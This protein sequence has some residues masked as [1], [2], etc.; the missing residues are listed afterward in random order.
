MPQVTPYNPVSL[1]DIATQNRAQASTDRQLDQRA[2][3]FQQNQQ[4]ASLQDRTRVQELIPGAIVEAAEEARKAPEGSR[5]NKFRTVLSPILDAAQQNGVDVREVANGLSQVAEGDFTPEGIAELSA[6]MQEFNQIT[7]GFTPE[8]RRKAQLIKA[9]IQPR[10]VSDQVVQFGDV[11]TVVNRNDGTSTPLATPEQIGDNKGIV[12]ASVDASKQGVKQSGEAIT[13]L[14]SVRKNVKNIDDAIAAIDEGANT[15]AIMS[16][17]PSI[18]QASIELD[19]A[20]NRLGLDI[21]GLVTFGALSK[22][23]LDLA[24]STGIPTGLEGPALRQWLVNKKDAQIALAQELEGAA[25]F[26]GKPGNT[27]ADYLELLRDSGGFSLGDDAPLTPEEQ[28]ELEALEAEFGR[29]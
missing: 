4:R 2:Q 19:N 24:L 6:G 14:A 5:V 12:A 9:G 15:G 21:I 23:E 3:E 25:I 10:A 18:T 1:T 20:R 29:R 17:L 27:P 8:E 11:P 28:A 16:R 26:L 13:Q 7:E 22:G